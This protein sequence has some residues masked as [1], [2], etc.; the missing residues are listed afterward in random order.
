MGQHDRSYKAFFAHRRMIQDLLRDR[1]E[2][3][4]EGEAL[5]LLQLLR[6]KFGPLAAEVEDRV[7][8]ADAD[9]LLEW[10]KRVLSADHL[11]DV[12]KD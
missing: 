3:R 1:Q 2:G 10:A 4:Q 6:L 5:M 12:F 8:S 9:R 11:E 7:R